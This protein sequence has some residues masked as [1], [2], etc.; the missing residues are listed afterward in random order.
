MLKIEYF[1]CFRAAL[2]ALPHKD[3]YEQS[4]LI[5]EQF[6]LFTEKNL[7]AYYAPF[8]Y[9]NRKARVVLV[10]LTPGWTQMH[11]AFC[12]AKRGM[13]NGLKGDDLFQFIETSSSFSGTMRPILEGML[14]GIGLHKCLG[15]DSCSDLFA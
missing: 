3:Q 14:N 9:M 15:I 2:E 1:E 11:G 10:G 8:H 13:A 12:A 4:D 6:S 7:K 5:S